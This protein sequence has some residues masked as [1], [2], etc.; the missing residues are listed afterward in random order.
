MRITSPPC[1]RRYNEE[2]AAYKA[3]LE[4]ERGEGGDDASGQDS[5]ADAGGK[6]SPKKK[7][8]KDPDAPKRPLTACVASRPVES[9]RGC[10]GRPDGGA[11][12][13]PTAV[14]L[15]PWPPGT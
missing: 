5:T 4:A 8:K 10:S 7:K 6:S 15:P 1:I 2:M 13:G 14:R 3:K 9:C 12:R 11:T